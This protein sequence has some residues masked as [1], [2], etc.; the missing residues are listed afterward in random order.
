MLSGASRYLLQCFDSPI[1][2]CQ[3]RCSTEECSGRLLAM[4]IAV[5]WLYGISGAYECQVATV[6]WGSSPRG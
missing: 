3:S 4:H 2:T 6:C 5:D 1:S